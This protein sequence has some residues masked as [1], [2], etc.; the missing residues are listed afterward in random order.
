[1]LT[2][3]L[4]IFKNKHDNKHYVQA[5]WEIFTPL[6]HQLDREKT[7]PLKYEFGSRGPKEADE[8]VHKLGYRKSI[9]Y[10]WGKM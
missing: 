10:K 1:M 7:V 6:L 8:L 4:L 9:A 5:A 2:S 3:T